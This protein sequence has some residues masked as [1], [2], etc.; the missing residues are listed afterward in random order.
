V[1]G[2][3]WHPVI[4]S[5]IRQAR[6][7]RAPQGSSFLNALFAALIASFALCSLAEASHLDAPPRP[8][9][10][11]ITAL[12]MPS[13]E[14]LDKVP[15]MHHDYIRLTKRRV[16][17]VFRQAFHREDVELAVLHDANAYDAWRAIKSPG[18]IAIFWFAHAADPG[19]GLIKPLQDAYG[20]D[21]EQVFQA[22][23]PD[24]QVLSLTG[25]DTRA[26]YKQMRD[27]GYFTNHPGLKLIGSNPLVEPRDAFERSLSEALPA[28]RQ[29]LARRERASHA[30]SPSGACQPS[31]GY[32]I[33]IRRVLEPIVQSHQPFPDRDLPG[34]ASC[35]AL[36]PAAIVT[37]GR[38]LVTVFPP[39]CAGSE[40]ERTVA[41]VER[42]DQ[43]RM[44]E[45]LLKI[46]IEGGAASAKDSRAMGDFE[47]EAS[48]PGARWEARLVPAGN[49]K[50]G[51]SMHVYRYDGPIDFAQTQAPVEYIPSDCEPATLPAVSSTSP[52]LRR[53][54]GQARVEAGLGAA[55]GPGLSPA[56]GG[57]PLLARISIG[58]QDGRFQYLATAR[59]TLNAEGIVNWDAADNRFPYFELGYAFWK[60]GRTETND[61]Q[62]VAVRLGSLHASR[63]TP[64]DEQL[65]VRVD[66]LGIQ[67]TTYKVLRSDYDPELFFT[68]IADILGYK[69]VE[70]LRRGGDFQ[71]LHIAASRSEAGIALKLTEDIR[72][73]AQAGLASDVSLG[74]KGGGSPTLY[75]K[76]RPYAQLRADIDQYIGGSRLSVLTEAQFPAVIE[77]GEQTE[78]EWRLIGGVLIAR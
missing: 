32:P 5:R 18:N 12:T 48:W 53:S 64:L 46:V 62:N 39:A 23:Q 1:Q 71:G 20:N 36:A 45:A 76:F 7:N 35:P 56:G 61:D 30:A 63:D 31:K 78:A 44:R 8:R 25:C 10:L 34:G 49:A 58:G 55:L 65:V 67:S 72:V 26:V 59:G 27:Q 38:K 4:D 14:T 16:E 6:A 3:N 24:T 52:T 41:W 19:K 9:V 33:K 2:L 13:Q 70:R 75:A 43:G 29:A 77:T 15:R 54:F 22:L 40:Q 17:K 74:L 28:I 11:L 50:L 51:V 37:L 73:R 68:V 69:S 47:I 21:V 57:M 42:P 60:A 66:L